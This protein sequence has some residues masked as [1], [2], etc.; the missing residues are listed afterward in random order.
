LFREKSIA[1]RDEFVLVS[2]V[3]LVLQR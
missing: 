2:Q 3:A 1:A